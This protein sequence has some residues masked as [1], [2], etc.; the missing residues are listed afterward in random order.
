ML[1]AEMADLEASVRGLVNRDL[2]CTVSALQLLG[3][4]QDMKRL[5][6]EWKANGGGELLPNIRE[7]V[8][9][10]AVKKDGKLARLASRN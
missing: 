4:R 5:I 6:G 2:D 7:R 8:G 3:L 1:R 9:L 10:R